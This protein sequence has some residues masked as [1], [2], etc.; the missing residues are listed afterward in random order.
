MIEKEVELEDGRPLRCL[1]GR[2]HGGGSND[3]CGAVPR[4][5]K[6]IKE[7]WKIGEPAWIR[8]QG[9]MGTS[10]SWSTRRKDSLDSN[11]KTSRQRLLTWSE[12]QG[13]MLWVLQGGHA[14]TF[15]QLDLMG[16]YNDC[17]KLAERQLAS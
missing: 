12:A 17:R 5:D 2:H 1:C 11:P 6:Q 15:A 9:G 4:N 3:H 16:R 14:R 8:E 10:S 13:E 7:T